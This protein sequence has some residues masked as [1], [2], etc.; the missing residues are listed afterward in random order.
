VL[1]RAQRAW[2]LA[3][4]L[5][6]S[7]CPSEPAPAPA[8]EP[9]SLD[10]LGPLTATLRHV[11]P[12]RVMAPGV[13]EI[14]CVSWTL[15]NEATLYV[16]SMRQDN[17][18]GFHHG[19]WLVVPAEV[20]P[21]DDGYWDCSERDFDEISAAMSGTI[22]FAQSTQAR[23]EEQR[24]AEGAV[25][26]IPPRSKV[27]ADIH[28][29]NASPR[30][31]PARLWLELDLVHPALVEAVLSPVLLS[32]LDLQ[33]PGSARSLHTGRCEGT[34]RLDP[35]AP[36][37]PP[38]PDAE[39]PLLPPP[40]PWPTMELHYVLPH[41]HGFGESFDLSVIGGELDGESVYRV[42]GFDA[43]SLGQTYDPPLVLTGADGLSFS[44]GYDNWLPEELNWGLGEGEMC[45]VLALANAD[46]VVI[47]GVRSGT[48]LLDVQDGVRMFEGPCEWAPIPKGYAHTM[49]FRRELELPLYVPPSDESP[50]APPPPTCVDADPT[51]A[52]VAPGTL[53]AVREHLFEPSCVFS[54]CHGQSAAGGLDL[55]AVDLHAELLGHE[56]RR[57]V[58]RPLVAEGDPE[59][60]YLLEVLSRCEPEGGEAMPANAVALVDAEVVAIV[61]EWIAGGALDDG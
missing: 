17:G 29:L 5:A 36:P 60:S 37:P 16:Q 28:L 26:K 21:G 55:R 57:D 12:E 35:E 11:L 18:G 27:V 48:E 56:L 45:L 58:S 42:E 39:P 9:P 46:S 38:D 40:P 19:N 54:S 7:A 25:I 61:R 6:G 52:A 20:Y 31:V 50:D 1:A 34:P 43:E 53:E 2:L 22:L 13:D 49:P 51:V 32:Y 33:I 10:E 41:F 8:P 15:N 4:A 23:S 24:F 14:V 59:G 47:G 3:L 30:E 44:C